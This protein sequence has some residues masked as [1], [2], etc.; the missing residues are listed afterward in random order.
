MKGINSFNQ[1]QPNRLVKDLVSFI[2]KELVVFKE[3]NDFKNTLEKKKNENQHSLAFCLFMTN[4]CQSKFYFARE[5]AQKGSSVV[6]I[7]IYKGSNIIFT[8][9]A[10]ILPIPIPNKKSERKEYEYVYGKG[11][12]IQRFKEEK[13]GLDNKDEL[14]SENGLVKLKK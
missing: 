6:D 8:I 7:G 14:L 13:H 1:L 5:N 2:E 9:E 12:G 11:A 3:S 4:Q 10:K